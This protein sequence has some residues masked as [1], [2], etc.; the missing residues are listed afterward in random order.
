[1][2]R[3]GRCGGSA[4]CGS[5]GAW[6][7]GVEVKVQGATYSSQGV[8]SRGVLGCTVQEGAIRALQGNV[9][10]QI[11]LYTGSTCKRLGP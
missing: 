3:V 6:C 4:G 7:I 11:M 8:D 5:A 9:K 1:M 2:C 10:K